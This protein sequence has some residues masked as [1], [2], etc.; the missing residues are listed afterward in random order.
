MPKMF[1]LTKK[2]VALTL[3]LFFAFVTANAQQDFTDWASWN[4]GIT[5]EGWRECL[6]PLSARMK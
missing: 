5:G 6:L 4:N 1:I 2:T 3:C